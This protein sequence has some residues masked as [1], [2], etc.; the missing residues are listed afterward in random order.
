MVGL[1]QRWQPLLL[2][3]VGWQ[4]L[5]LQR[6]LLLLLHFAHPRIPF[7]LRG[8]RERRLKRGESLAGSVPTGAE[9]E[10]PL[11]KVPPHGVPDTDSIIMSEQPSSG[12]VSTGA[13]VI[14]EEPR[15]P[16]PILASQAAHRADDEKASSSA[17]SEPDMLANI[18]QVCSLLHLPYVNATLPSSIQ[19]FPS[20]VVSS[21]RSNLLVHRCVMH[22][23]SR[24]PLQ[25]IQIAIC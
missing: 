22:W 25:K 4:L 9:T 5:Q 20:S 13:P 3:Q 21:I 14:P 7:A 19:S 8:H 18:G 24:G 2:G 16:L 23:R 17:L 1:L 12:E 15:S 6:P 11:L 10:A